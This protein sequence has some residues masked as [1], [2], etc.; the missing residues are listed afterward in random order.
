MT[1]EEAYALIDRFER[2]LC[3]SDEFADNSYNQEEIVH[4]QHRW[5][6]YRYIRDSSHTPRYK[7]TLRCE[8]W[9]CE[10][11]EDHTYY[12]GRRVFVMRSIKLTEKFE[13]ALLNDVIWLGMLYQEVE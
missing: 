13:N 8:Y 9:R 7:T 11:E 6:G 4:I 2:S 5:F 3:N 10:F 12:D 1:D